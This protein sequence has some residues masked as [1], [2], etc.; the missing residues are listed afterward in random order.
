MD[1]QNNDFD[2]GFR[3]LGPAIKKARKTEG[4][5][6]E[7]LSMFTPNPTNANLKRF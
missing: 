3:L 5:T 4:T 6:R 2:F 1:K 7:Q